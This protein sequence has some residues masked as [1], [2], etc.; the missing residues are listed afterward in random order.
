MIRSISLVLVVIQFCL[1]FSQTPKTFELDKIIAKVDNQIILKS[2]LDLA[3]LQSISMGAKADDEQLKCKTLENL[4]VNKLLL[5]KAEVDSITVEDKVVEDQLSR[6]MSYFIEQIGSE[7]KLEEYYNKSIDQLKND[8]RR[9]VREQM[10]AQKY[11]EKIT[12]KIKAT[13]SEVNKYFNSIPKDSLPFFSKEIVVGQ[14]VRVAAVDRTQKNLVKRKL[15]GFREKILAGESFCDYA[16]YSEDYASAKDCGKL[17]FFKRGELV[18]EYEAASFNLKPNELSSVIESQFGFHL[19]QLIERRGNEYN[20]RHILLKPN[21]SSVDINSTI[22][23]MDSLRSVVLKDSIKFA[24][25]AKMFSE[26]KATKDNGGFFTDQESGGI[27][28][29]M[30]KLEP[31]VFFTVDTMKVGDISKPIVF[32]NAEGKQA[33]KIVYVR[34]IIPAHV[35]NL[36]DDYQKIAEAAA[37]KKKADAIDKWFLKAKTEVFISLDPEYQKCEIL[38]VD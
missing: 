36:K 16:K 13:P 23:F 31:G 2:E 17:G 11:Q 33:V 18:P 35:A 3:L 9:Q 7:K 1:S 37:S 24:K 6:R 28:I 15:E 26:D 8:L 27:R 10:V 19:I 38:K 4:L 12:G 22:N 32:T 20:T 30:E 21:S 5:A 34:E 25:A 14:I 29:P